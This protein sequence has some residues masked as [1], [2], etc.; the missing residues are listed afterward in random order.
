MA[1]GKYQ[2]WLTPDGLLKLQAW[3]RDG[4]T[5]EQIAHN[6]GIHVAT[7]Y[8]YKNKYSEINEALKKGKEVVDIEVENAL[9][10]KAIGYK[11]DET[12]K[13]LTQ[14]GL[15]VTKVV[16]KEV[17]PDTTAQI[18]W[19]KNRKPAEWRDKTELKSDVT[20]SIEQFLDAADKDINY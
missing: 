20:L 9:F 19:L 11:Y 18:F 6:M 14:D 15:I 1:K 4:L 13:E 8:E 17:Q 2:E 3:A 12:T 5:D 7:L 16:T 10:K